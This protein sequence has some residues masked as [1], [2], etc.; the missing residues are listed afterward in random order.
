MP[1]ASILILMYIL[2]IC[3][4]PF[5]LSLYEEFPPILRLRG[6]DQIELVNRPIE[7][8]GKY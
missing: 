6:N 5:F 7:K 4:I 1:V 3:S 2:F 8:K